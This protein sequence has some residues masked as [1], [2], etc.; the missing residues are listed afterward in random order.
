[1]NEVDEVFM[2]LAKLVGIALCHKVL[3]NGSNLTWAQYMSNGQLF[4]ILMY[5]E[6]PT[7]E[8]QWYVNNGEWEH[9]DH[10]SLNS[11]VLELIQLSRERSG[12]PDEAMHPVCDETMDLF[13]RG[14]IAHA[15]IKGGDL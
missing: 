5:E 14:G 7:G 1:M 10:R 12:I 15:L 11:K 4:G 9:Y 3:E 2:K 6:L 13:I 8:T